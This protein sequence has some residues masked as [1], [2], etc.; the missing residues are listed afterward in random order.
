VAII[1][2]QAEVLVGATRSSGYRAWAR[3]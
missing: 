2:D 1:N 3:V